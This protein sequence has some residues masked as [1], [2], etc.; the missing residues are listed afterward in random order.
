MTIDATLT[1]FLEALLATGRLPERNWPAQLGAVEHLGFVRDQGEITLASELELLSRSAIAAGLSARA[2]AW[3]Q[4][5]EIH[6]V[7]ESTND[8]LVALGRAGSVAGRVC[9]AELQTRGRGRRGR[10][11]L[12]PFARHLAM[13]TGVRLNRPMHEVGGLSLVVGL[14][15]LDCLEQLGVEGIALKWPN[16]ILL[17]GRKLG[18]VLIELLGGTSAVEAVIG[19]GLN[20]DIP[21][22][23]RD[24]IDQSVTD[25]VA[26]GYRISRNRLASTLV[27][28]L[29]DYVKEFEQTGFAPM[30]ELF[31]QH[32]LFHHRICE[33]GQGDTVVIGRVVGVT[34]VGEI[35]LETD[36][37]TAAFG[38]GEVSLRGQEG[39]E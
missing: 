29:V 36:S 31:D 35:L 13:S 10:T 15:V 14:A 12:S 28:T 2:Q 25:L 8:R 26:A 11:W 21:A 19:V 3:L 37:G 30:R 23:V 38:A 6:T 16:D 18:G 39:R 7:L 27:S 1:A 5:L 24:V 20:V 17:H 33:I 4:E 22:A 9:F 32:H 34:E